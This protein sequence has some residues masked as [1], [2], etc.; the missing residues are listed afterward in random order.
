MVL[1]VNMKVLV[2]G[3]NGF[4]A[5]H[6]IEELLKRKYEVRGMLRKQSVSDSKNSNY[7]LFF[8]NISNDEDV[9]S[10]CKGVDI[11]IHTAATTDQNA[12]E[13]MYNDANVKPVNSIIRAAISC[14][15]KKLIYVSTANVFGYGN[16]DT[17]GHENNPMS[18]VFRKSKYAYSKYL[19]QEKLLQTS[20]NGDLEIVICNP[21]FMLGYGDKK[22]GA[23]R[24]LLM[25]LKN[26]VLLVPPGG[27]NFVYVKD[28]AI[29]I[30]NAIVSGKNGECYL[31][32]NENMDYG[33][34]FTMVNQV[35]GLKRKKI[36]LPSTIV[37]LFGVV[38]ELLGSLG[39]RLELNYNN[40]KILCIKSYYSS[41]KAVRE[42]QFPQTPIKIALLEAYNWYC[43]N[44]YINPRWIQK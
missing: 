17:P 42:L 9:I 35:L 36:Y 6:I 31:L 30:C 40:S 37:K 29:G 38:A 12:T 14:K 27:R 7:E 41:K 11:V 34:F 5:N 32:S 3:A 28:V 22:P 26:K 24:I 25:Y 19:A 39:M 18:E 33:N 43:E 15:C 4:L 13:G 21:T 44:G 8:G 23:G 20:I 2:T 10:A 1:H 16:E